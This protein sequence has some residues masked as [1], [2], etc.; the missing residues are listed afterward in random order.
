MR[1]THLID[2]ILFLYLFIISNYH[3][4]Y[5]KTRHQIEAQGFAS[6][7]F[8]QLIAIQIRGHRTPIVIVRMPRSNTT[9]VS[10][11]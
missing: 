8:F 2:I 11:M 9:D 3:L 4:Y 10:R 1:K 6:N 5:V 7:N